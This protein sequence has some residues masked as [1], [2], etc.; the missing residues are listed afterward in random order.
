MLMILLVAGFIVL[1]FDS[2]STQPQR[3]KAHGC[4]GKDSGE[5]RAELMFRGCIEVEALGRS[6]CRNRK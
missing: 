1:I 5:D 2:L 3:L 6:G 4:G